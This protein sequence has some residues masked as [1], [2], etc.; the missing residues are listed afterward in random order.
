MEL[1]NCTGSANKSCFNAIVHL[2]K[3]SDK[4]IGYGKGCLKTRDCDR[5]SK[6]QIGDCIS[7]LNA[8]Y[9]GY[10]KGLC[11]DGDKCND[12]DLFATPEPKSKA[13]AFFLSV[14]ALLFGV[15]LTVVNM[16]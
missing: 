10:C 7:A 5:Y 3:G 16:N 2:E 9:T 13:A 14:V 11:C 1:V 4:R 6:G 12:G 15:L 8:G